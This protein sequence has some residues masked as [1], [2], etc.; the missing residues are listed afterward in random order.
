MRK[1]ILYLVLIVVFADLSGQ[2]S[3]ADELF[4]KYSGK[5]GFS[6]VFI[7]S[8]MLGLFTQMETADSEAENVMGKLKSVRI[9]SVTDSTLNR[10]IN[11]HAELSRKM[12]FSGYEELM[13]VKEGQNITYFLTRQSGKSISELLMITG[14]P[15]G[16][17]M[18]SIK[19]DLNLND[20]SGLSRNMGIEDL[21]LLEDLEKKSP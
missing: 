3:P 19:G 1:I 9:L 18:I 4:N 7:S 20:I 16:N 6:S 17:S 11:F 5:E 10:K 14:G 13:V 2:T 12:D 15:G 21:K 8:K